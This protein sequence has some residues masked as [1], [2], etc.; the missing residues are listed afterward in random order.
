M[1][2]PFNILGLSAAIFFSVACSSHTD[3]TIIKDEP[4]IGPHPE[5]KWE[6]VS[7]EFFESD[8]IPWQPL[9][10]NAELFKS[11]LSFLSAKPQGGIVMDLAQSDNSH[12]GDI[13]KHIIDSDDF[14]KPETCSDQ[15]V[16]TLLRDFDAVFSSYLRNL[17]KNSPD[18]GIYSAL[19]MCDGDVTITS[20]HTVFGDSPGTN[21]SK[22]F[23]FICGSY[24]VYFKGL[25]FDV[26]K[27]TLGVSLSE[28]FGKDN[29]MPFRVFVIYTEEPFD[30]P[31]DITIEIP[32]KKVMYLSYLR[33]LKRD[34]NAELQLVPMTLHAEFTL[35]NLN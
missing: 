20:K 3:S 18:D 21:L 17:W 22:Y 13:N 11:S 32:V 23:K 31:V 28:R 14:W 1:K 25:S 2:S 6:I 8:I 9:E 10:T 27:H 35:N 4:I 34:A 7:G 15:K 29:M 19:L 5:P 30:G 12:W 16:Q 26:E 33:D 24:Q